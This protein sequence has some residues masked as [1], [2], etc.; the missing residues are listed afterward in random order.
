MVWNAARVFALAL[1]AVLC[2]SS[3]RATT[4][5][6]RANGTGDA[7]TI[8]AA[9]AI[10]VTGDT[11]LVESGTYYEDSI[12]ASKAIVI[13][14]PATDWPTINGLGKPTVILIRPPGGTKVRNLILRNAGVGVLGRSDDC[15]AVTWSAD[16]LVLDS[17]GVGLDADNSFCR[18]GSASW[19]NCTATRCDVG[20]GINDYGSVTASRLVATA[21]GSATL[22]HNYNSA[23]FNC[24]VLYANT[25]N[26]GGPQSIPLTNV[27]GA[28]PLLC[29]LTQRDFRVATASPCLSANN[30][31]GTQI[32]ALGLGCAV[33][34]SV[35]PV[36]APLSAVRIA[37][38][39]VPSR[40]DI[41]FAADEG[42]GLD[43]LEVYDLL[44]RQ[45]WRGDANWTGRVFSWKPRDAAGNALAPGIYLAR[46]GSGRE[47]N[48]VRFV[49]AK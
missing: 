47:R 9:A 36:V 31:C 20:Y 46:F 8:R 43:R 3:A 15:T 28:D 17:L 1:V 11:V 25:T 22:G 26:T 42:V 27:F 29:N 48:S 34:V 38:W 16:Q 5:R 44:G 37:A 45:V 39:P 10:A 14:G 12:T 32:G 41:V 30:S 40:G 23:V 2:A 24:L 18:A 35:D 7:P 21:C 13:T 49:L 19:T 4:I 33:S 6:V